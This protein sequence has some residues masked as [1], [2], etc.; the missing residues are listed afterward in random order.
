MEKKTKA[1]RDAYIKLEEVTS[2]VPKICYQT[3]LDAE[4]HRQ[5]EFNVL[6]QSQKQHLE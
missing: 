4:K 5:T 3:Q 1:I 6:S 2:Q